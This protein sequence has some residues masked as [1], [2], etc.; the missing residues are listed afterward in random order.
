MSVSQY[1]HPN[2]D[3]SHRETISQI[4]TMRIYIMILM[5]ASGNRYSYGSTYIDWGFICSV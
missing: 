2:F 1:R 3:N 4:N 5:A